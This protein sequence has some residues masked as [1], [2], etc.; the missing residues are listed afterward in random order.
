MLKIRKQTENDIQ[1]QVRDYLKYKGYYVI[2]HQMG[3][4]THAGMS[5][6]TAIKDGTTLYLE[7]KMA[8]GKLSEKQLIFQQ[9]IES[10]GGKYLVIRSLEDIQEF[11]EPTESIN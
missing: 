11:I 7:I 9:Q 1:G 10:H 5:D 6:L 2:R 8:K 4:G 3:L